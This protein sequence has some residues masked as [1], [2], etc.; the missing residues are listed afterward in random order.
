MKA[1]KKI[2]ICITTLC[3]TLA[4][5][6]QDLQTLQAKYAGAKSNIEAQAFSGYTNGLQLLKAQAQQQGELDILKS[7][8]AEI[9]RTQSSPIIAPDIDAPNG[10]VA[11]AKQENVLADRRLHA[12]TT[13]YAT[14]LQALQIRLTQAGKVDEAT[15]VQQE[16]EAAQIILAELA[17]KIPQE[18]TPKI[19]PDS[20]TASPVRLNKLQP[21]TLR[22][23]L[24]EL[25]GNEACFTPDKD[26]VEFWRRPENAIT[27]ALSD[28]PI[29]PGRYE[30][31][32][33]Y[34][35][36]AGRGGGTFLLHI[37][38][39]KIQGRVT[40]T[41]GWGDQK[42]HTIGTIDVPQTADK[43]SITTV[44]VSGEALWN[45]RS[46]TLTPSTH[47]GQ[48]TGEAIIHQAPKLTPLPV[49]KPSLSETPT[50]LRNNAGFK[51]TVY[52]SVQ[53]AM[54]AAKREKK[55]VFLVV[56]IKNNADAAW[57]N[58][59]I[60]G[61]IGWEATK[62]LSSD[63]FIQ[64][65]V[66]KKGVADMPQLEIPDPYEGTLCFFLTPT[67]KLF[68]TERIGY[69]AD[70]GYKRMVDIVEKWKNE[71]ASEGE[72]KINE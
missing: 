61:L 13:K 39:S 23:A 29:P 72:A 65:I 26:T 59:V 48:S 55:P 6:Q 12:L 50:A 45:L 71:K 37:G 44:S 34:S 64:A 5:A 32:I 1:L 20:A 43:V 2:L 15:E 68:W 70:T 66:D 47:S 10:I 8:I 31:A 40:A 58:W 49:H 22:A 35:L 14:A 21:V 24:G 4:Q 62:K 28:N 46:V 56:Y 67:G 63:N 54:N 53:T 7:V 36:E 11:L 27:W 25:A 16:Q 17:T 38:D 52:G 19:N 9:K 18:S 51:G 42:V 69:N 33:T 30:I 57:L 41:G 3:G 60:S